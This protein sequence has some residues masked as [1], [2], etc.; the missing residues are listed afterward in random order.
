M[1]KLNGTST[2]NRI[3]VPVAVCLITLYLGCAGSG[4]Q[5]ETER[6]DSLGIDQIDPGIESLPPGMV[7]FTLEPSPGT[8]DAVYVSINDAGGQPGWIRVFRGTDR[9]YLKERCEIEDCGRQ[10]AVCG[11]AI[12][13][14]QQIWRSASS[15]S[16]EVIW[17]VTTSV[18][19]STSGCEIR[20][21]SP[22][23]EY[24]ARFCYA[25]EAEFEPTSNPQQPTPGR[26]IQ[27]TCVE[28]IF[29]LPT[30]EVSLRL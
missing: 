20:Q 27:P 16:V 5:A 14:I 3:I 7:R 12:P 13:M 9:I 21:A 23:G 2:L 24:R 15:G 8:T 10:A 30:S 25:H 11:A 17:D 1:L 26:L 19:D 4:G 6:D 22:E 18:I 28:Q 29:I